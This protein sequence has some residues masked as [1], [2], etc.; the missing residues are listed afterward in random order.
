MPEWSVGL[1]LTLPVRTGPGI[2][3]YWLMPAF[4]MLLAQRQ[5]SSSEHADVT[6]LEGKEVCFNPPCPPQGAE[7]SFPKKAF[8]LRIQRA[9]PVRII[10][11]NL[12]QTAFSLG[13]HYA[14]CD[15]LRM[16]FQKFCYLLQARGAVAQGQGH[17]APFLPLYDSSHAFLSHPRQPPA[18]FLELHISLPSLQL[19]RNAWLSPQNIILRLIHV[20]VCISRPLFL[21]WSYIMF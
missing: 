9:D 12:H 20:A 17:P 4:G 2:P 13:N 19:P 18:C 16:E 7:Q 8:L 3:L 6:L 10:S 5:V 11:Q 21:G 1:T 15:T 14:S